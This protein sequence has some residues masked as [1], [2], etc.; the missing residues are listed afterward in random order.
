[1]RSATISYLAVNWKS[2]CCDAMRK[3]RSA[4][5]TARWNV[6]EVASQYRGR[7][8]TSGWFVILDFMRTF[9]QL[10]SLAASSFLFAACTSLNPFSVGDAPHEPTG[11]ASASSAA[12]QGGA[13][14]LREATAEERVAL[15]NLGMLESN[16]KAFAY[17]LSE[18][19]SLIGAVLTYEGQ[20]T[21]RHPGMVV[22]YR[23]KFALV[24]CDWDGSDALGTDVGVSAQRGITA[25]RAELGDE[26]CDPWILPST[27][28]RG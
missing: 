5:R 8:T 12:T 3:E 13:S 18:G 4:R 27:G 23:S 22:V 21:R 14:A 10:T 19:R 16:E 9:A 6:L 24:K 2:R 20:T 26:L 15:S 17:D 1:M 25:L 11:V 7:S 28:G